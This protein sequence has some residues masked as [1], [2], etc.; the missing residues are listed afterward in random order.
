MRGRAA[1]AVA[2]VLS[3]LALV[4]AVSPTA[5]HAATGPDVIAHRGSSGM[6]PENTAAAI[7]LAVR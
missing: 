2:A 6:A 3:G 4:L 5:A 1:G 7:D